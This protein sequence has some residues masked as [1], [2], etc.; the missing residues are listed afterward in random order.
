[1][2]DSEQ[3]QFPAKNNKDQDSTS[4]R[5]AEI[6]LK[7]LAGGGLTTM[8]AS[9]TASD[10]PQ[11]M[12]ATGIGISGGAVLAFVKPIQKKVDKELEESGES[13]V[14]GLKK[15][16][17]KAIP[18]ITGFEKRY[19]EALKTYCYDLTIEG[20]K[21]ELPALALDDV[22]VPL[23]LDSDPNGLANTNA[24]KQ[25]WDLLPKEKPQESDRTYRKLA[26]IGD[27]GHGKTTLMKYLTLSFTND[28]YKNEKAK[29]LFPVLLLFRSLYAEIQNETSPDLPDL[30]VKSI[31]SLPRCAELQP[32]MVWVQDK[33]RKNEVLVMLDGLDEVPEATRE[34]ASR[35]ANRQMQEYDTPFILTSRPHGF[36]DAD[37]F[38]GVQRV[39][40]LDF[41]LDQKRE[42]LEKWYT[43]VMWRQ[44]WETI[45]ID[46]LH[47]LEAEQLTEDSARAQ[48]EDDAKNAAADLMRQ[49][50][51]NFSLNRLSSNPLLVTIIAATHRAFE[52]LPD[53]RVKLYQKMF[54]LLLEDRPNRRE[55]RLTLRNASDNQAILQR[56]A[57][58]LTQAG[59]TQFTAVEG[60]ELI[61]SRLAEKAGDLDLKPKAF[62]R[63][64]QTIAGLLVGGD[65]DLY[66]FSHKTFQEF[67][68]AIEL[69]QQRK[70]DFLA[71]KLQQGQK[72]LNGWEEVVSFY[73][74]I[75]GADDLVVA[76]LVIPKNDSEVELEALKLMRRVVIEEKSAISPP[77]RK[78]LEDELTRRADAL[79]PIATLERKF[80]QTQRLDSKIEITTEP[81]SEEGIE[82]MKQAQRAG[83]F[84]YQGS[85]IEEAFCLWLT[86]LSGLQVEGRLFSYR[87]PLK[88]EIE[89]VEKSEP[90]LYIVRQEIHTRYTKLTSYLVS[91]QWREA[92]EET[93]NIMVLLTNQDH[94][95]CLRPIK[96]PD[97]D[98]LIIDQLWTQASNKHFGFS[99]QQKIW[100]ECGS[101][102][103]YNN[104]YKKLASRLGWMKEKTFVDYDA[105]MFS[106]IDSPIG[107]LPVKAS[108]YRFILEQE[109]TEFIKMGRSGGEKYWI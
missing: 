88:I 84:L 100:E 25:I 97:E 96:F 99:V 53:R 50:T 35:W 65:S 47:K 33:L 62:L 102:L 1:M 82:W 38:T 63:E 91:G 14:K 6:V 58:A 74:A 2:P 5:L 80:R 107:E 89:S 48:S 19:L 32:T 18:G 42:F 9:F 7:G 30:I 78:Q 34:M 85:N 69:D 17:D 27:P 11:K 10:L 3:N 93:S 75:V 23:R 94:N 103:K 37:L 56:L 44:K 61:E 104:D 108:F 36:E 40:V 43:V 51:G 105:L 83:H 22:F 41:T 86:T 101:P 46:S 31:K 45:Y 95:G 73:C 24:V 39:N 28:R 98:L 13:L 16:K 70:G 68:T 90:G 54:N 8:I 55:T 59:K 87:L 67:L 66:Q 76:T 15:Q 20:F 4:S 77:L 57:L 26:I 92:D 52:T 79:S 106:P 21:G 49:I 72:G 12:I 64:I 81:I 60:I 29:Q 109:V 71:S